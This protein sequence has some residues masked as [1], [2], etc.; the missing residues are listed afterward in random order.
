[1]VTNCDRAPELREPVTYPA[2]FPWQEV[3]KV[4]RFCLE[5]DAMTKPMGLR[6]DATAYEGPPRRGKV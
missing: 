3:T 6:K 2:R 1:V 4:W 5:V